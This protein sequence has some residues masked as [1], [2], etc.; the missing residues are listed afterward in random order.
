MVM[1]R[2]RPDSYV[3]ENKTWKAVIYVAGAHKYSEQMNRHRGESKYTEQSLNNS[4][5]DKSSKAK[6]QKRSWVKLKCVTENVN[7][8]VVINFLLFVMHWKV[9]SRKKKSHCNIEINA[10]CYIFLNDRVKE[11]RRP[12]AKGHGCPFQIPWGMLTV[13]R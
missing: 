11:M 12:K 5:K 13:I 6:I 8:N 4:R 2:H 9:S 1:N 3:F 7:V 10:Y